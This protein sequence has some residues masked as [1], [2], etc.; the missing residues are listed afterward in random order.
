MAS[1][2]SSFAT[3]RPVVRGA[4]FQPEGAVN[5]AVQAGT[6]LVIAYY[7]PPV[8]GL[9]LPGAQRALKLS[10]YLPDHGWSPIVLTASV[11]GYA[12]YIN[13]DEQSLEDVPDSISVVRARVFRVVDKLLN[14]RLRLGLTSPWHERRADDGAFGGARAS[15]TPGRG[16]GWYQRLKDSV[17]D[18]FEIPDAEAGWLLP[19]VISGWRTIRRRDVDV[20]YATGL[21]WT[22]LVVGLVLKRLTGKPLA[23]EF[24]DPWMT[25]PFR[26]RYSWLKERVDAMLERWVVRGADLVVTTADPLRTEFIARFGDVGDGKFVTLLGGFDDKAF[27]ERDA[28]APPAR[29]GAA[30]V[31]AHTGFLYGCRDPRRLLEAIRLLHDRGVLH[32]GE[33]RCEFAGSMQLTYDLDD[34]IGELG[35]ADDVVVHGQLPHTESLALVAACDMALLL[36]PGTDTQIP[37][38]L[39]EYVGAGKRVLAVARPDSA[40]ARL[41]SD[42]E[43]GAVADAEDVEAIAEAIERCYRAWRSQ[44]EGTTLSPESRA[45]FAIDARA[46]ELSAHIGRLLP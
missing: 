44:P 40:A 21:P 35:L 43:L 34:L 18:L 14:L 30:F 4:S 42:N 45:R 10:K 46:E 16:G 23:V 33:L 24:R 28:G 31:L 22:G 1:S 12:P 29:A 8:A 17:T 25:N 19:A 36:Q 32:P 20:I 9:G 27:A 11:P 7:F 6:V 2:P 26:L 41:V 5:E 3:A 38:K 39:Y 13:I 37:S 15:A